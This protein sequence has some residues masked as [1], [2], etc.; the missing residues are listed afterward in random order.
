MEEAT[1]TYAVPLTSDSDS[2][3][4]STSIISMIIVSITV[5]VAGLAG[6]LCMS[7]DTYYQSSLRMSI[8]GA[9][10]SESFIDG[11]LRDTENDHA[12][13][14]SQ[15]SLPE[16]SNQTDP[17]EKEETDTEQPTGNTQHRT[18]KAHWIAD[19]CHQLTIAIIQMEVKAPD[20]G[21]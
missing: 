19:I 10:P 13:L 14:S 21:S 5:V 2:D 4:L 7:A 11:V 16:Q 1:S 12:S 3:G 17:E 8:Q 9:S 20:E 6:I 18:R 15:I